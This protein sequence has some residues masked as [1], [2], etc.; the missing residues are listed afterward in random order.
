M[1]TQFQLKRALLLSAGVASLFTIT[2]SLALGVSPDSGPTP[3]GYV[4][5]F[6]ASTYADSFTVGSQSK[7]GSF[8]YT[9]LVQANNALYSFVSTQIYNQVAATLP[10]MVNGGGGQLQG[11]S[12]SLTGP[13]NVNVSSTGAITISGMTIGINFNVYGSEFEG[14]VKIGVTCSISETFTSPTVTGNFNTATG[15]LGSLSVNLATP[16]QGVTCT[17]DLDEVPFLGSY[18]DGQAEQQTA[19]EVK[20]GFGDM[21]SFN[22]NTA[23][24]ASSGFAGW[25]ASIPSGVY[26]FNG[27]DYGAYV[28]SNLPAVI[29][30]GGLSA[31]FTQIEPDGYL[32][33]TLSPGDGPF[34]I[35][36]TIFTAALPHLGI[37]F[38]VQKTQQYT[39]TY[40][41]NPDT[42]CGQ[43]N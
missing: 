17:S 22:F 29:N 30:A 27:V 26:V 35:T 8:S 42:S 38:S 2:S 14:P 5:I 41:C 20:S 11:F 3:N 34:W 28:N 16:N 13:I 23:G 37:S 24:G 36:Q 40:H 6:K 18:I 10:G 31:S 21:T 15:T 33:N 12:T 43:P 39:S 32:T 1:L 7:S 25:P 4:Y 9:P 19:S